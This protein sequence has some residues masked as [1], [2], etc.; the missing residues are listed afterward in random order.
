MELLDKAP[1]CLKVLIL[2]WKFCISL[3]DL[4]FSFLVSVEF[5]RSFFHDMPCCSMFQRTRVVPLTEVKPPDLKLPLLVF[6]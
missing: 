6:A 1:I 3:L 5:F 4:P 2:P